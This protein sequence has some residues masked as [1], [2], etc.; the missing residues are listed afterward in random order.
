[1]K[2]VLILYKI[3]GKIRVYFGIIIYFVIVVFKKLC[4][5]GE[6]FYWYVWW[7]RGVEFYVI[8]IDN[9]S[10]NIWV[11]FGFIYD[12]YFGDKF[13]VREIGE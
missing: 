1:M 13:V 8:I 10:I 11:L 2:I 3:N 7:G 9:V 4:L 6:E 12:G 5:L